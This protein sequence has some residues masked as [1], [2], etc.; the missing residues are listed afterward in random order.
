MSAGL[1]HNNG[2]SLEGGKTWRKHCWTKARANL[3]PHLP[4]EILR[5]RVRRS[6]EL[7]LDYK[8]YASVRAS[9]G[10]DVVGF[11]F[12]SNALRAFRNAPVLP[13]TRVEKLHGL[14]NCSRVAVVS[15]PLT[16]E[17]LLAENLDGLLDAA[18]N[19]P[20]FISNWP[21]CRVRML[22]ALRPDRLPADGMILIGD[23]T[24]EREWSV[25]GRLAAYFPADRYFAGAGL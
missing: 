3:I 18:A 10:R 4:I 8:T 23:T 7:G 22:A 15:Q 21:E 5:G 17:Q 12:S 25:A 20:D 11:L 6:K 2:P 14:K 13:D 1:G 19:A 24:L 16:V 9:T